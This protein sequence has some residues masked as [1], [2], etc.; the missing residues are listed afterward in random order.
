MY[1]Q[2]FDAILLIRSRHNQWTKLWQM[3]LRSFICR[4]A[5]S[6]T[7][8]FEKRRS[9]WAIYLNIML[10]LTVHL[11]YDLFVRLTGNVY[12]ETSNI[13]KYISWYIAIRQLRIVSLIYS[14]QIRFR[15]EYKIWTELLCILFIWHV[16]CNLSINDQ[17]C[18]A[19]NKS[20]E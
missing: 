14:F 8:Q 4:S 3:P 10:I 19:M 5:F 20:N 16:I 7:V 2:P 11:T 17:L 13:D 15:N 1:L 6:P 12:S 18:F 9:T